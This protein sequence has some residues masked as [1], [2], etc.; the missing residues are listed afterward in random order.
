MDVLSDVLSTVRLQGSIHSCPELSA[1]WGVAI[2][3]Q[4]DRA[5]F[6][7][8]SRGSCYLEVDGGGPVPL[9]G[10]DVVMLPHGNA[11]TLR[12]RLQTPVIPLDRLLQDHSQGT[13][14]RALRRLGRVIVGE[15]QIEAQAD[16]LGCVG[17]AAYPIISVSAAWVARA[18]LGSSNPKLI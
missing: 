18:D 10:G 6:Y 8:L 7:V 3:A 1:P 4:P 14:P 15:H 5:P 9:A 11:H 13:V 16:R 17:D 2:P 12:D